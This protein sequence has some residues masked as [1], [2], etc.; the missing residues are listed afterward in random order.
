M[1]FKQAM[2]LEEEEGVYSG[3]VKVVVE[4]IPYIYKKFSYLKFK[5][6]FYLLINIYNLYDPPLIR[7]GGI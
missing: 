2:G 7:S 5:K 6:I 3:V 1:S 4:T